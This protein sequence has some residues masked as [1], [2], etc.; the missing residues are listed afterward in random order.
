MLGFQ[1]S[2]VT[3]GQFPPPLGLRGQ[4]VVLAP[5][6]VD[7]AAEMVHVLASPALYA[8]IGGT[9]PSLS[10]LRARYE[11]QVAGPDDADEAWRNW[12]VR[13][14]DRAVGFVQATL[15]RRAEVTAEIAW[16]VRPGEQGRGA[17]TDAAMTMIEYLLAHGVDAI[18][19]LILDANAASIQVAQRLGMHRSDLEQDGEQVWRLGR[20]SWPR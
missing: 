15:R 17:A 20:C 2:S 12:I 14:D 4:R 13:V 11:R 19:A 9:P 6:T 7:A 5:L 10:D 16:L 3:A 8:H 18:S 1:P